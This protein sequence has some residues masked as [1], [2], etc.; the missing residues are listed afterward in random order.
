MNSVTLIGELVSDPVYFCTAKGQDLTRLQI[1]TTEADGTSTLHHCLAWGPLA[2]Q[3]HQHLRKGEW[4]LLRG[5]IKYRP[6]R[7]GD[8]TVSLPYIHITAHSYLGK[9]SRLETGVTPEEPAA[10][11]A[12]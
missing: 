3:L 6:L 11:R 8:R 1:R 10:A 12:S 7:I 5:P 4:S 9:V 2:L